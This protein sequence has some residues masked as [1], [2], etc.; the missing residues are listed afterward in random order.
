MDD[1]K[2]LTIRFNKEATINSDSLGWGGANILT[3]VD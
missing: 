2:K 3:G 1:G